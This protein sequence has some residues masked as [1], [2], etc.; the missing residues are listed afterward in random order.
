MIFQRVTELVLSLSESNTRR[1][2]FFLDELKEAG[3]LDTLP[4]LLTKGR[5][6]GA[7]LCLAFQAYEGLR[8]VYGDE[9]AAEIT[10]MCSN[11]A[12]LRTDSPDT[13]KWA[14]QII[15]DMELREWTRSIQHGSSS[16]TS[17]SEHIVKREA[18]LHT[19]IMQLPLAERG[20]FE[21]YFVTPGIG[22]YHRTIK[23]AHQLRPLGN[24]PNFI[25]RPP[26]DQYLC[27]NGPRRSPLDGIGPI[28]DPGD[29]PDDP[30]TEDHGGFDLDTEP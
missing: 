6:K 23:F 14:A 13:A 24:V 19:Q 27:D 16:T 30:T 17:Q 1:A 25:P 21:G 20:R 2:W 5:S 4:R 22:V 28:T 29:G 9:L 18:I 10:G 12:F 11:K 26:E 15:G 3:R 7:R 8:S